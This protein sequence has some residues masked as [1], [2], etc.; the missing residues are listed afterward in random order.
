VRRHVAIAPFSLRG[1]IGDEGTGGFR[2]RACRKA[3]RGGFILVRAMSQTGAFVQEKVAYKEW[4]GVDRRGWRLT[5]HH[6]SP[7]SDE[8]S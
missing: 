4:Y 2:L 3:A 7:R 5:D 1:W 8:G 6:R